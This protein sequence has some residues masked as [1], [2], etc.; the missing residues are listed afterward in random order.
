MNNEPLL[1]MQTMP[2]TLQAPLSAISKGVETTAEEFQ[3][4]PSLPIIDSILTMGRQTFVVIPKYR[5]VGILPRM[6]FRDSAGIKPTITIAGPGLGD[7]NPMGLAQFDLYREFLDQTPGM[8][9]VFEKRQYVRF[10]FV[11]SPHGTDPGYYNSNTNG[12]LYEGCPIAPDAY[13]RPVLFVPQE[14]ITTLYQVQTGETATGYIN[15]SALVNSNRFVPVSGYSVFNLTKGKQISVTAT[16]PANGLNPAPYQYTGWSTDTGATGGA[17]VFNVRVEKTNASLY[18]AQNAAMVAAGAT[19]SVSPY[20][21]DLYIFTVTAATAAVGD[22]YTNNGMTFT[23]HSAIAG[24]T[25]LICTGSGAPAASG[26][27]ARTSGAGTNP[28]VF[29]AVTHQ[30]IGSTNKE[31]LVDDGISGPYTG[32]TFGTSESD[33]LEL[34][35]AIAAGNAFADGATIVQD[36]A[37]FADANIIMVTVNYGH[38]SIKKY[39]SVGRLVCG[40]DQ[41]SLAGWLRQDVQTNYPFAPMMNPVFTTPLTVNITAAQVAANT[42][43]GLGLF[44]TGVKYIDIAKPMSVSFSAN[45]GVTWTS[46]ASAAM[47][48]MYVEEHYGPEFALMPVSGT[49]ELMLSAAHMAVINSLIAA[50][51]GAYPVIQLLCSYKTAQSRGMFEMGAMGNQNQGIFNLTDG[52]VPG[53]VPGQKVSQAHVPDGAGFRANSQDVNFIRKSGV[54]NLLTD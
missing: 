39:A 20:I 50:G 7:P 25:T 49:L 35:Q 32:L 53:T 48:R 52:T 13:G 21:Q 26:N 23:V 2:G 16:A 42:I 45:N 9:S 51:H 6:G 3:V 5:A 46:L 43:G 38:R 14:T 1:G 44:S 28:I 41:N 19:S 4:D 34:E 33:T 47:D 18:A 40:L 27:L 17:D 8:L 15:I 24:G 54:M 22:L 36:T 12:D 31:T 10:P 37:Q 30:Q 11:N 29:S